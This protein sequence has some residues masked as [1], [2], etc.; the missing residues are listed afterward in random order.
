M[1]SARKPRIRKRVFRA[2]AYTVIY[3][4]AATTFVTGILGTV[5]RA[6]NR[7]Y[8]TI[9]QA[10]EIQLYPATVIWFVMSGLIGFCLAFLTCESVHS[11]FLVPPP[12]VLSSEYVSAGVPIPRTLKKAY[13]VALVLL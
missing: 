1:S 7:S 8:A 9:T 11:Y 13:I 10:G 6:A 12:V 5:L 3:L 4:V 2:S